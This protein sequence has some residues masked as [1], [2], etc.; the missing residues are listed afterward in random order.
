MTWSL[1]LTLSKVG[2]EKPKGERTLFHPEGLCRLCSLPP[3]TSPTEVSG[4]NID[5][6]LLQPDQTEK[7]LQVHTICM[8]RQAG[9]TFVWSY[10]FQFHHSATSLG[11]HSCTCCLTQSQETQNP[12]FGLPPWALPPRVISK[13][14]PKDFSSMVPPKFHMHVSAVSKGSSR[15]SMG[16]TRGSYSCSEPEVSVWWGSLCPEFYMWITLSKLGPSSHCTIAGQA[17]T[18]WGS[19]YPFESQSTVWACLVISWQKA[20]NSQTSE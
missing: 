12:R 17:R 6:Y 5:P 3:H 13:W 19:Q 1:S 7:V 15:W 4:T 9:R 16:R 8:D 11:S 2:T 20:T 18:S 10:T 14:L